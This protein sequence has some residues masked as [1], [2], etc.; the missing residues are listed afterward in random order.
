MYIPTN[1]DEVK[2]TV[3][4]VS[5]KLE[6]MNPRASQEASTAA[7]STPLARNQRAFRDITN[8]RKVVHVP[9]TKKD[10]VILVDSLTEEQKFANAST[11]MKVTEYLSLL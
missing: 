4:N 2:S 9:I 8:K 7:T 11:A 6:K 5:A 10:T 1:V 3:M